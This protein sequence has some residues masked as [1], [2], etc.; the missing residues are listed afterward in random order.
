M[1]SKSET[2]RSSEYGGGESI[3]SAE[4]L[5]TASRGQR[6]KAIV[7][8]EAYRNGVTRDSTAVSEG[9][10]PRASTARDDSE[11]TSWPTDTH[12]VEA[13]R[14]VLGE[15]LTR[16]K[17]VGSAPRMRTPVPTRS[18]FSGVSVSLE[19]MEFE[20]LMERAREE[21]HKHDSGTPVSAV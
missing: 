6:A 17:T 15:G 2:V 3:D 8:I 12:I 16:I 7:D 10:L 4:W 1:T 13:Q 11:Q 14:E 19:R 21:D 18:E 5:A 9:A 20:A